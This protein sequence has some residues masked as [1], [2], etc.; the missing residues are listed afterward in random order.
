MAPRKRK[1]QSEPSAADGTAAT[2]ADR[3]SGAKSGGGGGW[4]AW[5]L[6]SS[7]SSSSSAPSTTLAAGSLPPTFVEGFHDEGAVRS[8]TYRKLG[9][10][11]MTVSALSLGASSLGGVFRGVDHDES[12]D[13]VVQALRQG[14]NL[15]DTAP[16]YGH[17]KSE[18]VLGQALKYVRLLTRVVFGRMGAESH[19]H[20]MHHQSID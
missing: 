8:M 1:Q 14:I 4:L 12:V 2:A 11:G 18:R 3:S 15:I 10:T 9:E 7:T 13:V 5:L 6:G 19:S 17:G 16:W 20:G